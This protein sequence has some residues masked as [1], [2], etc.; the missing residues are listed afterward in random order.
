MQIGIQAI[1]KSGSYGMPEKHMQALLQYAV[2]NNVIVGMRSVSIFALDCIEEGYP[3]KPFC[4]K[5]KTSIVGP[6]AGLIAIKPV[7]SRVLPAEYDKHKT[8]L[9]K[10]FLQDKELKKIPLQLSAKRIKRL[11]QL[12]AFTIDCDD[13][14][15]AKQCKLTWQ[16]AGV[17]YTANAIKNSTGHFAIYDEQNKPI[18]VLG[19]TVKHG[20]NAEVDLP[21]TSDYD[22]LVI[23]PT[24]TDFN[25]QI[26]NTP[27]SIQGMTT[28]AFINNQKKVLKSY[29]PDYQGPKENPTGGNMSPRTE[30]VVKGINDVIKIYDEQKRNGINLDTVHH[31]VE[32]GNP[33]ADDL[34]K[35]FPCLLVFPKP[36]NLPAIGTHPPTNNVEIVLVE[37]TA[38]LTAIRNTLRDAGYYW[39]S[40]AKY[41]SVLQPFREEATAAT[42][43][44]VNNMQARKQAGLL[45]FHPNIISAAIQT[46]A[47]MKLKIQAL[48]TTPVATQSIRNNEQRLF[49]LQSSIL[50]KQIVKVIKKSVHVKNDKL[51]ALP[52]MLCDISTDEMVKSQFGRASHTAK[53]LVK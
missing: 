2:M 47:K 42:I 11:I 10:A 12:K 44:A 22:L 41:N 4:V 37:N 20:H 29:D 24:F 34:D 27:F 51:F 50:Q 40:H 39:S 16:K 43:K 48:S 7:Y 30:R 35:Q 36:I 1:I 32:F 23:C 17:T 38:E 21:I 28:N 3:T 52:D 8:L 26:D 31:N 19:K 5:N 33:F 15:T 53:R 18:K 25:P 45:P 9:K 13:I 49:T 14:N 46:L 6:A